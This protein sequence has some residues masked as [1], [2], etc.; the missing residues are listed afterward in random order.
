LR[1]AQCTRQLPRISIAWCSK[2]MQRGQRNVIILSQH[3]CKL[4]SSRGNEA[5]D[6]SRRIVTLFLFKQMKSCFLITSRQ[7]CVIRMSYTI[8]FYEFLFGKDLI[9]HWVS[10]KKLDVFNSLEIIFKHWISICTY[11]MFIYRRR[12]QPQAITYRTRMEG[13]PPFQ[14]NRSSARLSSE[15]FPQSEWL[16]ATVKRYRKPARKMS[17]FSIF[18]SSV[19]D[20]YLVPRDLTYMQ[21]N[22]YVGGATSFT[23]V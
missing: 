7:N 3:E 2:V 18:Y 19:D 11:R 16:S 15:F 12:I 14:C 10:V 6:I 5:D 20:A 13:T 1:G 21:C 4:L 22:Y 8:N 23:A 17:R 9:G